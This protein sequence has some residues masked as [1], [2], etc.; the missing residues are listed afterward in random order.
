M[1][2][3]FLPSSLTQLNGIFVAHSI[4]TTFFFLIDFQNPIQRRL[5]DNLQNE[6]QCLKSSG[7]M[8]DFMKQF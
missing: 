3:R 1:S 8:P 5:I 2:L 6:M 7:I 4:E